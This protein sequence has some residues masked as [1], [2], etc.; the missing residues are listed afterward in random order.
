[1]ILFH[2]LPELLFEIGIHYYVMAFL[3]VVHISFR[4][5][6]QIV[7]DNREYVATI[8]I[9]CAAFFDLPLSNF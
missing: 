8:C 1:M 4:I 3:V 2:K 7:V 6:N 5:L 9:Y